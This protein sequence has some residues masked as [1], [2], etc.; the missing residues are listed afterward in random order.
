MNPKQTSSK[1]VLITGASSGIGKCTADYLATKGYQVYGT[2]R[3]PESCPGIKNGFMI[4]MDVCNIASVKEAIAHIVGKE[5]HIDVLI[6]NAGFGIG[7]AIEDTSTEMAKALFDTNFFGICRVLQEVLPVMRRQSGGLI[8]NMSSI[9]G[10]IGL[11]FQGIYSASKFAVEGLSEALYKE[12]SLS[13]INVVLIEPGDFKTEFTANRQIINTTHHADQFQRTM[14]VIENDEQTGQ[15][16]VKIAH[17]IEKII[18]TP[19][20]GLRYAV[21]AFDQKLSIFLK[22]ILPNRWFDQIIMSYYQ[23]K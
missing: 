4:K 22:K 16:P 3:H 7:G 20:P 18:N 5:G 12:L 1:T 10:L 9:G 15:P 17:L 8:I 14:T 11:P 2:S 21:G 23:L 13:A 19:N 6:N